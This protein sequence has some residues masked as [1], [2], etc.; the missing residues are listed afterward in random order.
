M[1]GVRQV[2]AILRR[3]RD[4][5]FCSECDGKIADEEVVFYRPI[6]SVER[7]GQVVELKGDVS[8][9]DSGGLPFHAGC[10]RQRL[11]HNEL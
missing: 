9:T 5:L 6:A 2:G 4:P 8:R 3:V 1:P 10:L 11:R 7:D